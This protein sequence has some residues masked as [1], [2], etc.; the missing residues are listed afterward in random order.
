MRSAGHND[1]ECLPS[2]PRQKQSGKVDL[3]GDLN[4]SIAR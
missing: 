1:G 4:L 3:N 2:V